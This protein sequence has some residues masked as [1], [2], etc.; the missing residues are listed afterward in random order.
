M[1]NGRLI[2]AFLVGAAAGAGLGL[3]LAPDSG[4]N[5][6]KKMKESLADLKEKAAKLVK[7]VSGAE[8]DAEKE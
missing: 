6:R 7:K 3:L 1:K 4:K 8:E 5:T 2:A